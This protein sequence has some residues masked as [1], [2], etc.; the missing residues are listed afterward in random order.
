MKKQELVLE[1]LQDIIK[2]AGDISD[3]EPLLGQSLLFS[4]KMS[5]DLYEKAT[6]KEV[7]LA[8]DIVEFLAD[9]QGYTTSQ[10]LEMSFIP[11]NDVMVDFIAG[12]DSGIDEYKKATAKLIEEFK[13]TV[14]DLRT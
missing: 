7:Y 9:I 2:N 8:K 14:K 12:S 6:K 13:S 1:K 10:L 3:K 5:M 4:I 11:K